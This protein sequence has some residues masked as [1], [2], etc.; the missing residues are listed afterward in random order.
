[1]KGIFKLAATVLACLSLLGAVQSAGAGDLKP[2]FAEG[3][4]APAQAGDA[5]ALN[6]KPE[7]AT[8]VM[9]SAQAGVAAGIA[10][11]LAVLLT[12]CFLL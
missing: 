1:M 12:A 4:K 10:A 6:L 11:M 8:G 3:V 5:G 9:A 2:E 7:F